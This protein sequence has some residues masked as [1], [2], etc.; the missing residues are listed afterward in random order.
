MLAGKAI[1]I[2]G[3]AGALGS[4]VADCAIDYGAKVILVD[5]IVPAQIGDTAWITADLNDEA[6]VRQMLAPA[7]IDAVVHTAGGFDYGRMSHEYPAEIWDY[8]YR[9]NVGTFLNVAKAV[10]PGM[11]DR[12]NGR[13]VTIGAASA[14]VGQALMAPY[15]AS[16]SALM[17]ITES[18]SAE[19]KGHG[20]N[21]NCVAPTALNTPAARAADP[22]ADHAKWV[23]L[24]SVASLICFLCSDNASSMHG[25][26]VPIRGQ[27]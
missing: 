12:Q 2:T 4:A 10:V 7:E 6:E 14:T 8:F 11:I 18:M 19:L 17:R 24:H 3:G 9:L 27:L 15:C 5:R 22:D 21:V 13:I 26:I 25:S 23:S 20:I 1:M 16:K